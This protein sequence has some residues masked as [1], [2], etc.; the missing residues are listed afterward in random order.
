MA[1]L[2]TL[3][4]I[5]GLL[6]RT[7]HAVRVAASNDAVQHE[8]LAVTVFWVEGRRD[9][10]SFLQAQNAIVESIQ[11]AIGCYPLSSR[12]GGAMLLR[13][14]LRRPIPPYLQGD[15]DC[16]LVPKLLVSD[17]DVAA[18]IGEAAAAMQKTTLVT[19]QL[20]HRVVLCEGAFLLASLP[21]VIIRY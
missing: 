6:E 12:Q 15:W 2:P 10:R 17:V 4:S 20:G 16:W 19:V 7:L 18:R 8:L 13:S 21:T 1:A 9:Q 14:I 3:D 5:K 11:R